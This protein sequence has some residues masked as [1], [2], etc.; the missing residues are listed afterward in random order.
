MAGKFELKKAKDGQFYFNLKAANGQII[1]K[2]EIYK[3]KSGAKNGIELIKKN[4]AL[5]EQYDRKESKKGDPYFVLLAA[6]KQIIVKSEMYSSSAARKKRS[7]L[8]RR[9]DLRRA[10]KI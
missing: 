8:L 4:S 9:M 1:L 10:L 5:D 3:A 2:S 7:N 6:I